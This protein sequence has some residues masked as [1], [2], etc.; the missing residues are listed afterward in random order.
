MGDM[1]AHTPGL[2]TP[3]SSANQTFD[4]PL[5]TLSFGALTQREEEVHRVEPKKQ[6]PPKLIQ[7]ALLPVVRL[8]LGHILK[9]LYNPQVLAGI[10]LV[11]PIDSKTVSMYNCVFFNIRNQW[12]PE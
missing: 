3:V 2:Y 12:H 7:E 5:R 8:C 6:P 4:S 10:F 1:E 11:K 9:L